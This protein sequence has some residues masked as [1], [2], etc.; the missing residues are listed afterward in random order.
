MPGVLA[1][2]DSMSRRR[3][4]GSQITVR[5]APGWE[6]VGERTSRQR[7]HE[8][9]GK[10]GRLGLVVMKRTRVSW[11]LPSTLITVQIS[12]LGFSPLLGLKKTKEHQHH[13]RVTQANIFSKGTFLVPE[14]QLDIKFNTHEKSLYA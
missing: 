13:S 7:L 5:S 1:M 6:A 4:G 11:N 10:A 2:A 8:N 9:A 12:I 3:R 14:A